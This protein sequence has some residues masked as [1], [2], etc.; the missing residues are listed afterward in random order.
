MCDRFQCPSENQVY[1]DIVTALQ[2]H[3]SV[4]RI[5][6]LKYNVISGKVRTKQRR[7]LRH[8]QRNAFALHPG[9]IEI[10]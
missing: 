6:R 4:F 10:R 2:M 9:D 8:Q 1:S 7:R 3:E 5:F